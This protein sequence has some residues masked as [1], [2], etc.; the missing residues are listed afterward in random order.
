VKAH[1]GGVGQANLPVQETHEPPSSS[2]DSEAPRAFDEG[3]EVAV[4]AAPPAPRAHNGLLLPAEMPVEGSRRREL[5]VSCPAGWSEYDGYCLLVTSNHM[6][7]WNAEQACLDMG[8]HICSIRD[9]AENTVVLDLTNEGTWIGAL[10]DPSDT[11]FF[12]T[13]ETPQ[14]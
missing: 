5:L 7:W 8:A 4:A 13:G 11:N 3:A 12:W 2:N 14:C 9:A 1:V 6:S 10:D